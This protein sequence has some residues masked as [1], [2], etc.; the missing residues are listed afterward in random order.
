[1]VRG[2]QIGREI[3]MITVHLTG[4]RLTQVVGALS[5]H[6][7]ALCHAQTQGKPSA[8]QADAIRHLRITLAEFRT[9]KAEGR[10]L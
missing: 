10:Q 4:F 3:A 5:F 7:N 1:M 2:L 8:E 9:I 6:L